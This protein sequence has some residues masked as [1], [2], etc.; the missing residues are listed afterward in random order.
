MQLPTSLKLLQAIALASSFTTVNA[1]T[2]SHVT[3]DRIFDQ[4]NI[5]PTFPHGTCQPYCHIVWKD[6]KYCPGGW[7]T[8]VGGTCYG[9]NSHNSPGYQSAGCGGM[10]YSWG[11]GVLSFIAPDSANGF[12]VAFLGQY[13]CE[14]AGANCDAAT[15]CHHK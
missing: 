15:Q 14:D 12:D 9:A 6:D 7:T 4:G 5:A 2:S 1:V 8:T 11:N 3:V 13:N 10:K